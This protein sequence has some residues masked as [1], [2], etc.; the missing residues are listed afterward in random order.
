MHVDDD[1]GIDGD[2]LLLGEGLPDQL[3]QVVELLGG[4]LEVGG[5]LVIGDGLLDEG[6]PPDLGPVEYALAWVVAGPLSSFGF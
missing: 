5:H 1:E 3:D 6:G 2:L 4:K